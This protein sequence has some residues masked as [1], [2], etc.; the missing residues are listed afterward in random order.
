MQIVQ[1]TFFYSFSIA[2]QFKSS[3]DLI[4]SMWILILLVLL[5]AIFIGR[6]SLHLHWRTEFFHVYLMLSLEIFC[7]IKRNDKILWFIYFGIQFMFQI[8][9]FYYNEIFSYS[10][11]LF[12]FIFSLKILTSIHVEWQ[13]WE[14]NSLSDL[15]LQQITVKHWIIQHLQYIIL[16]IVLNIMS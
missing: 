8:L 11:I 1:N 5:V 9:R 3:L 10:I 16:N 14:S 13:F 7:L 2:L 12:Y 15:L 4:K 6:V